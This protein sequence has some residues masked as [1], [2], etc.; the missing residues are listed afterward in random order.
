MRKKT[1]L[2]YGD[3]VDLIDLFKIIWVAKIK[4][5]LITTISFLIGI[6]TSYLIPQNYSNSLAIKV[7]DNYDFLNNESESILYTNEIILNK[8][9]TELQDYEEFLTNFN[10]TKK[11]REKISKLPLGNQLKEL[12]KYEKLLEIT[13]QS[14]LI[15]L[16]FKWDNINEATDILQN[17]VNLAYDNLKKS[18]YKE[19][20][21]VFIKEKELA[22]KNDNKRLQFL[23]EQRW[24][25]KELGISDNQITILG[26]DNQYLY[27]LTGYRAIDKQI[28]VIENRSYHKYD[29]SEQK[30]ISLKK[31]N[32]KFIKF[33]IRSI[34]VKSLINTKL[35]LVTSV[36]L[37]LFVSLCYVLISHLYHSKII[38]KKRH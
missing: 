18:I 19:I 32:I 38:S 15:I 17:T 27:Y 35:I 11:T 28:D 25:A 10:N 13:R 29:L 16:N 14:N 33:D 22:L 21:N 2:S 20:K 12:F 4:I 8:F 31:K 23:K 30:I 36:F 9:I 26:Q 1:S 37:G 3:E 24:I 6:G 7:A 34:Q 5:I